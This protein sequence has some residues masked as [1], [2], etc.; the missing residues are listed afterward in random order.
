MTAHVSLDN[1]SASDKTGYVTFGVTAGAAA[2][3][4]VS[5]PI[6]DEG[7]QEKEPGFSVPSLPNTHALLTL[8]RAQGR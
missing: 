5:F 7:R 1:D 3:S 6:L 8:A 2:V 4:R